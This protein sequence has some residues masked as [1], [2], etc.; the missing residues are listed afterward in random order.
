MTLLTHLRLKTLY[1]SVLQ[2]LLSI[3]EKSHLIHSFQFPTFKLQ[4]D[5]M[6]LCALAQSLNSWSHGVTINLLLCISPLLFSLGY[7]ALIALS[8]LNLYFLIPFLLAQH[9]QFDDVT[10]LSRIMGQ[11]GQKEEITVTMIQFQFWSR[12]IITGQAKIL[13]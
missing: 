12:I 6:Q 7:G 2:T 10:V 8:I 4:D 9:L 11:I 1:Y 3:Q 13:S 5:L